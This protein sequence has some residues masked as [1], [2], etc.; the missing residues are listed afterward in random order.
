[1]DWSHVSRLCSHAE[2]PSNISP[3]GRTGVNPFE[4]DV[5][6]YD[7]IELILCVRMM[8][9]MA[10]M[11]KTI[12]EVNA[13]LSE[14]VLD[15]CIFSAFS[16]EVVILNAVAFKTGAKIANLPSILLAYDE[17]DETPDDAPSSPTRAGMHFGSL[18]TTNLGALDASTGGLFEIV[19]GGAMVGWGGRLLAMLGQDSSAPPILDSGLDLPQID[20]FFGQKVGGLKLS[21]GRLQ[22]LGPVE[23]E[24]VDGD[25]SIMDQI[26]NWDTWAYT[27]RAW[28]GFN[29]EKITSM[30]V[31]TATAKVLSLFS[32]AMPVIWA[33]DAIKAGKMIGG[34]I[35]M[36]SSSPEFALP[37]DLLKQ[38]K[39]TE[40]GTKAMK[41][42]YQTLAE[43]TKASYDQASVVPT[44]F[45]AQIPAAETAS[46]SG[47]FGTSYDSLREAGRTAYNKL[48]PKA[49]VAFSAFERVSKGM[50]TVTGKKPSELLEQG[51]D[52]ARLNP[53]LYFDLK[54]LLYSTDDAPI[55]PEFVNNGVLAVPPSKAREAVERLFTGTDTSTGVV[56]RS[57]AFLSEFPAVDASTVQ[58][59]AD[60]TE[61]AMKQISGDASEQAYAQVAAQCALHGDDMEVCLDR[62]AE[63]ADD[64]SIND[65][66]TSWAAS[67]KAWKVRNPW[68]SV[69]A[70][71]AISTSLIGCS[72]LSGFKKQMQARN[73]AYKWYNDWLDGDGIRHGLR[74][75]GGDGKVSLTKKKDTMIRSVDHIYDKDPYLGIPDNYNGTWTMTMPRRDDHAGKAKDLQKA[76]K[77]AINEQV[78][79]AKT[80]PAKPI[81]VALASWNVQSP[82]F[83]RARAINAKGHVE[84]LKGYDDAIK[85]MLDIVDGH[86]EGAPKRGR[87]IGKPA[88]VDDL[89]DAFLA[90]RF[91]K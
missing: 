65:A 43:K 11:F 15:R 71:S 10:E 62:L 78:R 47:Y 75:P 6:Q 51:N 1:M 19:T 39:S 90:T 59:A 34:V 68:S 89:V 33:N 55:P 29:G 82:A 7:E 4:I 42:F 17:Q 52:L 57:A 26:C 72:M 21:D 9:N 3:Y 70:S 64:P 36:F 30:N 23:G 14:R 54:T 83:L 16:V 79:Q 76:R 37:M 67:L 85:L 61:E 86:G 20:H 56:S 48:A 91:A 28:A 74:G 81:N 12:P 77:K 60:L 88:S 69:G 8:A 46:S 35:Q 80:Y 13:H 49:N 66:S 32:T 45:V 27:I 84:K 5:L 31:I 73:Q 58:K 22:Y 18:C 50:P 2:D 41:K 24:G 25:R 87:T 63:A 53:R 44:E 40:A 38:G